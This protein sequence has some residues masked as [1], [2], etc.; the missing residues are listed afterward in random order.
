M[1]VM[2]GSTTDIMSIRTPIFAR[3]TGSTMCKRPTTPLWP[4]SYSQTRL[5]I[6]SV[7]TSP[8]LRSNSSKRESWSRSCTRTWP[9][10]RSLERPSRSIWISRRSRAEPTSTCLSTVLLTR[11]WKSQ[12]NSSQVSCCT[13]VTSVLHSENLTCPPSGLTCYLKSSSIRVILSELR[14]WRSLWCATEWRLTSLEAKL[15]SF[16]LWFSPFLSKYRK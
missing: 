11:L 14:A 15:A 16:S 7:D 3:C 4:W 6:S 12:N 1:W 13:L 8:S 5:T 10:W 9:R 2:T